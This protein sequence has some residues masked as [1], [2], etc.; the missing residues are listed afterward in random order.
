M[1]DWQFFLWPIWQTYTVK[2]V[3]SHGVLWP[4]VTWRDAPRSGVGVWPIWGTTHQRE[5]DHGYFLWPIVTWAS[6]DEDRDTPGAG[7]SWMGWPL[8][9][10]I[11]RARE[12]QDLLL[13]PFFSY[14]RTD[15]ATRGR[16]PWPLVEVLRSTTR[17]RMSIWPFWESVHGYPYVSG[18][19]R[20]PEEETW[21]VGWQLMEC[22]TLT[23]DRTREDR[24]NFFPFWT[25]ET[26]SSQTKDGVRQEVASYTR[27]W[28]F[29]SCETKKG[30]SY[31]RVLELV[32]IRHAEGIDRNWSPF[33]TFWEC[34][35]R[36]D[37]RTR[38]SIFW[39][40]ITWHTGEKKAVD[41]PAQ[42]RNS[43]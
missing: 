37:G 12:S 39:S 10:Q 40:F 43:K 35:D 8:Y 27:L 1:D 17:D 38:H 5:S 26:R 42:E 36:P 16:V 18:K 33:W 19:E 30:L 20:K 9:G 41:A 29:W 32:P 4:F 3:R 31:H 34:R 24:F 2:D 28:P 13:P 21:R 15:S 22:T 11:R 23:T 6:Y 25:H 14:T 7:W